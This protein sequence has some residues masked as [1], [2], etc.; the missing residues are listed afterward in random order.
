M[1][2]APLAP[3][4]FFAV[5]LHFKG[6]QV[7]GR[8]LTLTQ[9][10]IVCSCASCGRFRVV[11]SKDFNAHIFRLPKQESTPVHFIAWPNFVTGSIMGL[12][13]WAVGN[14]C[15]QAQPTSARL[16]FFRCS[17]CGGL[18]GDSEKHQF[19]FVSMFFL[20]GGRVPF[21]NPR[22]ARWN[23]YPSLCCFSFTTWCHRREAAA[24]N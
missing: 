11:C 2:V 17:F 14:L 16:L 9:S 5:C 10:R 12:G 15:P 22:V 13:S 23:C 3:P 18:K 24:L 7:F 1:S 19:I 8:S 21:C 6:C 20:I 4:F